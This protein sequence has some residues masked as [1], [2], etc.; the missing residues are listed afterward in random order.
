MSADSSNF[1][2]Q[3]TTTNEETDFVQSSLDRQKE[4]LLAQ[5]TLLAVSSVPTL[6]NDNGG[7]IVN[8][9]PHNVLNDDDTA[10]F[11]EGFAGN[12][13]IHGNGGV[14]KLWG[15]DGNDILQ[16]GLA[17][18][19]LDGGAGIDTADFSDLLNPA[20]KVV[21]TV[22]QLGTGN[23]VL[24][25]QV[26]TNG[27]ASLVAETDTLANF[28]SYTGGAGIDTI[29]FAG[30]TDVKVGVTADLG[31]LVGTNY[32]ITGGATGTISGFENLTGGAG[33]DV[34]K[35]DSN[36]NILTGGGGS[37]ILLGGLGNDTL[38]GGANLAVLV[39][40]ASISAT[41]AG[42]ATGKFEAGDIADY[43]DAT[44]GVCVTLDAAGGGIVVFT[45]TG[46][47]LPEFDKLV[48]IESLNGGSGNDVFQG[49]ATANALY[50]NAGADLLNGGAGDDF[51]EGGTGND[52]LIGGL[53]NDVA[54]FQ[55]GQGGRSVT[56]DLSNVQ[57]DG[58]VHATYSG[59][60]TEVDLLTE[61]ENLAGTSNGDTLSGDDKINYLYGDAGN[62]TLR[63][64]AGND[65]LDGGIGSDTA[66]YS[67]LGTLN[68]TLEASE[69]VTITIG[70]TATTTTTIPAV[71][72][73]KITE[74]ALASRQ[75]G[76]ALVNETDTLISIENF[77]GG[78]NAD[79]FSV[80]GFT[81]IRFNATVNLNTTTFTVIDTKN[82]NTTVVTGSINAFEDVVGTAGNDTITGNTANNILD[83]GAG[84]DI[85]QG[86]AGND[87]LIGGANFA[88]KVGAA[89]VSSSTFSSGDI[90]DYSDTVGVC[91]ILDPAGNGTVNHLR[92][93]AP[94]VDTLVG[95]ESVRGGTTADVLQ[96]NALAN[97]LYGNNGDDALLGGAGDDFLEGGAGNDVLVGGL[98]ND[99]ASFA[100]NG[101][102]VTV[103]L[104][105]IQ[106]DGYVHATFSGG[107]TEVDYL[108]EIESVVG[109][110]QADTITGD[111]LA[112]YLYGN[113]GADILRG[114]AGNDVLDGGSGS[115]TADYS[116]LGAS[117]GPLATSEQ[118][119]V[120]IGAAAILTG[121]PPSLSYQVTETAAVSRQ[122][123]TNGVAALVAEV[124]TLKNIEVLQGG[125]NSNDLVSFAGLTDVRFSVDATLGGTYTVTDGKNSGTTVTS[126]QILGFENL[127]GGAGND[128]LNG[129]A[130]NN[131]LDSGAGDD[132]LQGRGGNDSLIGGANLAVKIAIT[133]F[134]ASVDKS[135]STLFS[136]GDAASWSDLNNGTDFV[137]VTLLA[138]A[139]AANVTRGGAG[140]V[141]T[142]T[143]IESLIGG[144]GADT[145]NGD[146]LAN[147]IYGGA[148]ID[149]INGGLGNDYVI[150]GGGAD[151]LQGGEGIDTLS[152]QDYGNKSA[153]TIDLEAVTGGSV[154]ATVVT[155]GKVPV[156]EIDTI[157]QNGLNKFENIVGTRGNDVIAG[158]IGI[159][160]LY[161]YVGNDILRG[162]GGNDILNGGL[163]F[164][165]ATY[166]ELGTVVGAQ[167]TKESVTVNLGATAVLVGT[168]TSYTITE[169]AAVSRQVITNGVASLVAETDTLISIEDFTGGTNLL[170]TMSY[171]GFADPRFQV[172]ADLT[173]GNYSVIDV[174]NGSA[175]VIN[176]NISLF[177]NLIGG[178][179]NDRL[180]GDANV[181][182]IDGGGGDDILQ[183]NGGNDILIGGTNLAVKIAITDFVA[184]IDKNDTSLFTIGDAASWADL[185]NG[186]DFVSV[187]LLAGAATANV[188]RGGTGEV[189]TLTG[190]ESLIGGTGAD[191]LNGDALANYVNGGAGADTINGA[192]GNDYI[193]GGAGADTL[194][195]GD[196]IDTLSYE[197]YLNGTAGGTTTV[198]GLVLDLETPS[199][200]VTITKT[201]TGAGVSTDTDTITQTGLNK[202][203][204]VVG[205]GGD[206][207]ISGD[208]GINY[209]Y[210]YIGSDILRGRGG[211]DILNGGSDSDTATYDELG[212]VLGN[213]QTKESVTVTLG[214]TIVAGTTP[215][216]TITETAA[217]SRQVITNGVAS[218]VAETDTLISIESFVGGT[219]VNDTMS[220]AGFT[221]PRFQVVAN[222]IGG[223]YF[224]VDAKNGFTT[225]ING[226]ISLFENLTG[227]AGNDMFTGTTA[228]NKLDGGAGDDYLIGH[229]GND[230]LIG[231][232][233]NIVKV[234]IGD[235]LANTDVKGDLVDW[236]YLTTESITLTLLDT[237]DATAIVKDGGG[238]TVETDKVNGI[239]SIIAAGGDDVLTGNASANYIDAGAGHNTV[240]GG[241]GD[242][243]I[244]GGADG[245]LT[246]G[247][248]LGDTIDGGAGN[249][250]F[251]W[252]HVSSAGGV[253]VDLAAKD[254]AGFVTATIRDS[255]NTLL[256]TDHLRSIENLVGGAG[257]DTLSGD[258]LNNCLYGGNG[259]DTLIG[260][261]GNDKLEGGRGIDTIDLSD[262]HGGLTAGSDT[263]IYRNL[264]DG[265]LVGTNDIHTSIDH[266]DV[267]TGFTTS[268]AAGDID[269]IDLDALLDN[270]GIAADNTTRAGLVDID[271]DG[272]LLFNQTGFGAGSNANQTYVLATLHAGPGV[273]AQQFN[274][275][276]VD[277]ANDL[278]GSLSTH[279]LVF[280]N[281]S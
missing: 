195:G 225:V 161:G 181:N 118:V 63:G 111:K 81:D 138:G 250:T 220:Y 222:L 37:D 95:I 29:S 21:V 61:I 235:I 98:G 104:S 92:G 66:T 243:Y 166:D 119:A 270:L 207:D 108:Q 259:N 123:V 89:D 149:S 113:G 269:H 202:F 50:G 209:L 105:N 110:A 213:F 53:G 229:G 58:Y 34:L 59:G 46:T 252:D 4:F 190:I 83:G 158:D 268:G 212:T 159:N 39:T 141:D 35:G 208:S 90:A 52:T 48:G 51:L 36:A 125:A 56:V 5:Q 49:N 65:I 165:E 179:G 101:N 43:S 191:T 122:I 127:T 115:D 244:I 204:N 67:E 8:G 45:H 40:A 38:D 44:N 79:K 201:G 240:N 25:R 133:D 172:T 260:G 91:V 102:G 117:G 71:T 124:D 94:D 196:G 151:T 254:G 242:D 10:S 134:V 232:A 200:V 188:T 153:L 47:G 237:G 16:G 231:G 128:T 78:A 72:T 246:G 9:V 64:R 54:S 32:T 143:G 186:T 55:N 15:N 281:H 272:H 233:N 180:T 130:A 6:Q 31:D 170:D 238:I 251:G 69:K 107:S 137:S 7:T 106:S 150:G 206:D 176:G 24:S 258:A 275:Q 19:A 87:T 142:L 84:D 223:S 93:T 62:D 249:D 148:G 156:T 155:S 120:T 27:V 103:D 41:D 236:T 276:L 239:E 263:V 85:L 23:A 14:D 97:A 17:A 216:Y 26:V 73:Y 228:S 76:T 3:A 218:L 13:I 247:G 255:S 271:S 245:L 273:T 182:K 210:G 279:Q 175:T 221:D 145:L 226:N 1:I 194:Q 12:D 256:E 42:L 274:Q 82:G 199:S 114:G 140:E 121:T 184:R 100:T 112:N 277:I 248:L 136:V 241:G 185:N 215:S 99:V 139:G 33:N 20:E 265:E 167:Q 74:T 192:G 135:D 28:E 224:V 211:N 198:V 160:Y 154:S 70:G 189:D 152:Y 86:R 57:N 178:A 77:T 193:I 280:L 18:D 75:V 68:N 214:A 11:I 22:N 227:G 205:T 132:I 30:I 217:V 187:T 162:R 157:T 131:I 80:A 147:Y 2:P 261:A 163:G 262:P 168:T 264:G 267:I 171:I 146:A 129:D 126:G 116:E 257:N 183:G 278:H 169:T 234:G 197:N 266:G 230:M 173:N 164:D 253:T 60:S 144:T 88:V 96:G 219:N 174:K 109:S 177:E 203:E